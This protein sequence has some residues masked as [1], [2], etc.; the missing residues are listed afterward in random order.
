MTSVN[1]EL[2]HREHDEKNEQHE[3]ELEKPE[4]QV[5]WIPQVP[6]SPFVVEIP[7]IDTGKFLLKVLADYDAFQF[8]KNI[9]PDYSNVGGLAWR[10]EVGTEGE[11]QDL[12]PNDDYDMEEFNRFLSSNDGSK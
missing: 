3:R 10:H 4:L 5:W 7:D 1:A 11:W 8:D 9:K 2:Y 6:M 12:D